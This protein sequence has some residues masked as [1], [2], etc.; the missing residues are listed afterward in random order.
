MNLPNSLSNLIEAQNEFNSAAFAN[1]FNANAIVFDEGEK[2]EG[3][4]A[5]KKWNEETNTKYKAQL[6]AISY[7]ET[8]KESVLKVKGSG[9]FGAPIELNY[10]ITLKDEL[11]ET[12]EIKG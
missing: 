7:S 2:Y 4:E 6:E 12:L 5:I 11:I 3:R 9:S 10:H 8:N 1:C